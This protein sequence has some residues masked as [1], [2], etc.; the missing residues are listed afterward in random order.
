VTA[1]TQPVVAQLICV[2]D[3]NVGARAWLGI[4]FIGHG[5]WLIGW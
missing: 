1:A 2:D 4:S 5:K 3:E